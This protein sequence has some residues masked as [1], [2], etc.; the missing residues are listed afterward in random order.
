MSNSARLLEDMPDIVIYKKQNM[1]GQ[2]KIAKC[3]TLGELLTTVVAIMLFWTSSK[4][5][6]FSIM[7]NSWMECCQVPRDAQYLTTGS[8]F[9]FHCPVSYYPRLQNLCCAS[10]HFLL[11]HDNC[12]SKHILLQ[13]KIQVSALV[14]WQSA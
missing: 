4:V 6:W 12:H 13:K 8:C 3:V 7:S 10:S 2:S 1:P 5:T 14:N 9:A 11:L